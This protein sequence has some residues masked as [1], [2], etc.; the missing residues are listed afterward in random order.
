VSVRS[1]TTGPDGEWVLTRS[2][3]EVTLLAGG[4]APAL[5]RLRLSEDHVDLALVN[6]PPNLVVAATRRSNST[7]VSLHQ[8]PELD[9]VTQL[10]LPTLSHIVTACPGRVVMLSSDQRD[11]TIIRAAGRGLSV[12]PIDLQ[13][14]E[15]EF[16]VGLERNQLIVSLP[17]RLEVWDAVS[18]RPL[19][20]LTL[21]LPPPPRTVGLASGNLWVIRPGSDEVLAYRLSDGRPFQHYV[22]AQ[23]KSV[24][25][26]PNSPFIVF[27]TPQGLVRLHCFAHSVL[28]IDCP[29]RPETP[30]P[31]A[32]LVDADDIRLLGW[33]EGAIA[34]WHVALSGAGTANA[35]ARATTDPSTPI[36]LEP[37]GDRSSASSPAPPGRS[38]AGWREELA[39]FGQEA[40]RGSQLALPTV[41]V[42]TELG[43]LAHRL[44]LRAPARHAV[45]AMY[46]L[47]LVGEPMV[48][49]ATLARMIDDWS[50]PLGQGQLEALAMVHRSGGTL[51]LAPQVTDLLD[52]RPPR[53]VRLVGEP[54]SPPKAEVFQLARNGRSDSALET[55]LA[56]G[57]GRIAII[58]SLRLPE[59][60]L[61]AR[62][63]DATAVSYSTVSERPRPWPHGT[64]LI[65]VTEEVDPR[66]WLAHIARLDLP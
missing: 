38:G 23:I 55:Q 42:D 47:Y 10:E 46:A 29:W 58:E 61:E 18:G 5:G 30:V 57:L 33:P 21:D 50:E 7:E 28:P 43:D 66:G 3:R 65:V 63:Y 34:P 36:R 48:A 20:K 6:G 60:I 2:D 37:T 59:A 19:R 64:G 27:E 9:A 44:G 15:V 4:L 13:R 51:G 31:L 25:S 17:R 11:L 32:Q 52:G 62:L 24:V 14:Q 54:T 49:I 22:G 40:T 39:A 16:I 45:T 41:P 53:E 1:L 12:H 26:H 56:A 35:Q 8:P